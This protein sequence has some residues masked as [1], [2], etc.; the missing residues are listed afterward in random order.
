MT[1]LVSLIILVL[2]LS[3][4]SNEDVLE[5]TRIDGIKLLEMKDFSV[6][7]NEEYANT[8]FDCL[9]MCFGNCLRDTVDS[10]Y[11]KLAIYSNHSKSCFRYKVNVLGMVRQ[12]LVKHPGYIIFMV[13]ARMRFANS[14]FDDEPIFSCMDA[15]KR[16]MNFS[17][18]V[19]R[20]YH[21][22]TLRNTENAGLGGKNKKEEIKFRHIECE[23]II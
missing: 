3:S 9:Q 12:T 1:R 18:D 8:W 22:V 15:H 6:L 16:G 10:D 11:C 19:R 23:G 2:G 13:K 20:R 5:Y 14:M 7:L 17:P 4:C 21:A